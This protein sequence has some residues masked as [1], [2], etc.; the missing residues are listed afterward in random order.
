[1][2]IVDVIIVL[3]AAGFGSLLLGAFLQSDK[4]G[5]AGVILLW[6]AAMLVMLDYLSPYTTT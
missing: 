6:L 5:D 3:G 4:W 1:M 2:T